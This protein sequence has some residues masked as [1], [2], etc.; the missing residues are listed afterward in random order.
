M[1]NARR[2]KRCL[3]GAPHTASVL[4]DSQMKRRS[5]FL[6]RLQYSTCKAEADTP[7]TRLQKFVTLRRAPQQNES[8]KEMAKLVCGS[9][10]LLRSWELKEQ[11]GT[12]SSTRR[13]F[14]HPLVFVKHAFVS[15]FYTE[16]GVSWHGENLRRLRR[17]RSRV[18]FGRLRWIPCM[19]VVL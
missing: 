9:Q 16:S 14:W 2:G 19:Q 17:H 15:L 5:R 18:V 6:H 11:V 1:P 7:E 12:A 8:E 13:E 4:H 3:I 10:E